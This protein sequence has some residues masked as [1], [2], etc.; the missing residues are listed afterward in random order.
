[1]ELQEE[2]EVKDRRNI[3][4][5]LGDSRDDTGLEVFSF[6]E[7]NNEKSKDSENENVGEKKGTKPGLNVSKKA[8][9]TFLS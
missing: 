1:M 2:E 3:V 5:H 8:V 6:T 7:I 9:C 4:W